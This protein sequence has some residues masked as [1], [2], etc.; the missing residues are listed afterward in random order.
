MRVT[1]GTVPSVPENCGFEFEGFVY[2]VLVI[3]E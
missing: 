2:L 1:A 3:E